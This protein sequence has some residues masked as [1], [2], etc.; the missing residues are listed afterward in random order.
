MVSA[1]KIWKRPFACG[2]IEN[3]GP[4]EGMAP[5]ID[6]TRH[7]LV[8]AMG[9]EEHEKER[10]SWER[11]VT[12]GNAREVESSDKEAIRD[13]FPSAGDAEGTDSGKESETFVHQYCKV[14]L[15]KPLFE[16]QFVRTG[17]AYK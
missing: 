11:C 9:L 1:Y 5:G 6:C 17:V 14:D 13:S 12:G 2:C 15:D 16:R 7:E 8:E 3:I 4:V 10:N